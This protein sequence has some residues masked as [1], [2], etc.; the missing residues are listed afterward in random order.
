AYAHEYVVAQ[1]PSL[2][3]FLVFTAFRQY[4]TGRGILIPALVVVLLANGLNV[5]FDWALVFGEFGF[6][7]MGLIGAGIATNVTRSCMVIMLAVWIFAGGLHQGAWVP[8]SKASFKWSGL[9]DILR[10][11]IPISLSLSFEIWAFQIATY[12][13]GWLDT[14]D[15]AAHG[16]VMNV[17]SLSFMIPLGIAIGAST[18][19][20]NLIGA[21]DRIGAQRTAWAA[22]LMGGLSM[23]MFAIAFVVF[24]DEIPKLYSTEAK[25]IAAAAAILPLAALFQVFD[26]IQVVG[27]GVL[28]GMGR[29][30]PAVVFNFIAFYVL[31]LPI[32]ATL[33]FTVG[34]GLPGIWWG[35]FIGLAA[36][37]VMLLAWIKT[38]GPASASYALIPVEEGA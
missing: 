21:G 36:V 20:G 22:I 25:V 28:R 16:I 30:R 7:E 34:I 10:F 8:W 24:R 35:L 26:G 18:R 5:F 15:L 38:R 12:F 29:T 3:C 23:F 6:P 9:R 17:A 37:A 1:V 4:L 11:G 2:P 32:G 14:T 19:V 31:A 33:T 27:S 13:A